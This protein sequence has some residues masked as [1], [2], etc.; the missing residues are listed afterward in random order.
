MKK[1]NG[2][3]SKEAS[4]WLHWLKEK[5]TGLRILIGIVAVIFLALFF[6]FREPKVDVLELNA[7]ANRYIVAQV[8]F[9]F[10]DE[11][12]TI[13]L[14]RR[15]LQDFSRVYQ[16]NTKQIKESR[17]FF[18]TYLLQ[19]KEWKEKLS[20][21][22]PKSLYQIAD[23][24]DDALLNERFT[25]ETTI[26]KIQDLGIF[27][28]NFYVLIPTSTHQPVYLP[29][30]FWQELE[31][32][33]FPNDEFSSDK[34][35]FVMGFFQG[36]KWLF[37]YDYD[38]EGKISKEVE[39]QIPQKMTTIRAGTKII[40]QGEKVTSR[41]LAML[42]SMKEALSLQQ[43]TWEILP[44]LSSFFL[45]ILFVVLFAWYIYLYH[46]SVFE[47]LHQLSLL[48]S[49]VILTLVIAK[50][51]EYLLFHKMSHLSEVLR[52]PLLIP[53]MAVLIC[54]LIECRLGLILSFFISVLLSVTLAF[55]HG[56]FL[57]LN[58]VAG[59]MIVLT[60]GALRKRKEI[61]G[62]CAKAF[63]I[64]I[65]LLFLFSFADNRL[66]SHALG[67]DILSSFLFMLVT[68]IIVIGLLPLLESLFH[69]MT[70]MSLME[71]M[72]P[73]NELLRRLTME[74]PGTYQH[75]LVL[76]NIAEAA[77]QAIGANGLFC[78]VSTLYHDIGKLNNPHFF[79][80]NQ[81]SGVNIHQLLT[82]EESAQVIIS[83]VLDGET[84]AR[85]YRLPQTFIDVIRQHHGTSLVYFF[86]SKEVELKGGNV[87]EVDESK[88]RYPGPPPQTKEAGI[89]M[90]CDTIEAASRS[91]EDINE[92]VLEELFERLV[93]DK[94]EDGQ[95]DQCPI[96]FEEL[97]MIKK[98]II[99]N[100]MLSHH[101]RVKYPEK[102]A[103]TS[104]S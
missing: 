88:F 50:I 21:A 74:I 17:I 90:I 46:P 7:V 18:E 53:F 54:T 77:A 93:G 23:R 39:K 92:E 96:T 70:D 95:F 59:L 11:G 6:H 101:V 9:N 34:I 89:I 29:T 1:S 13:L 73:N 3:Y 85:K 80:E 66:W 32:E 87:D 5:D 28:K 61:F 63:L 36:K 22:S 71:F 97:G 67:Y 94:I 41:H 35:A 15:V 19:N 40:D 78:R 81:Q 86:Y 65:P 44:L 52:Y 20:N 100:L 16:L 79:T 69:V 38:F 8:D 14:K 83:H 2:S 45:S 103:Q 56:R 102:K 98:T 84:L 30:E 12:A 51:T 55:D 37:Q 104:P 33:L 82:P 42:A 47:S 27:T 24:I 10:P 68:A 48:T 62:V 58:L 43:N 72:D 31:Q 4:L 25:D 75:C 91:L 99:K 64:T 57:I 49:I 60:S 76:G 26:Q